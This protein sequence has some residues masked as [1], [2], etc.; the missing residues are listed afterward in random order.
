MNGVRSCYNSSG[1]RITLHGAAREVT[2][3]CYCVETKHTRVLVD[4]GMFQGSSYNDARNFRDFSFDA[5]DIDAVIITHAHLDHIG[6]LPK[7]TKEGFT[8]PIY[9]T[10]P[11]RDIARIVLE[12]ANDIMEEEFKREYRPKLYEREDLERTLTFTKTLNYS[13]WKT[14]G[15]IRF[16]FRDAGHIFGSAFVELEENGG[17]RAVFSGD[18]GNADTPILRPTAQMGTSDAVFIESTYGNRIHEDP[19]TRMDVFKRII[20]RTIRQRGV[21]LIPAFAVERTQAILYD[22]NTFVEERR[23]KPIDAYIDSPM[24]IQVTEVMKRYPEYYDR[25]ALGHVTR[26]DDLFDFPRLQLTRTR[27]ESKMINTSPNPK[28][29]IAGSG[30]MNGGRIKHHLIRYLGKRSTTLFIVGYQANGTLGRSLYEGAKRVTIFHESINVKAKIV[31]IGSF[32]AH[33][34]QH[35][36]IDWIRSA[37]SL[38]K[39]VY[40]THGEEG[41]AVALATKVKD[42]LGIPARAPRFGETITI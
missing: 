23:I 16:R 36:L 42:D 19:G 12:D 29:I 10:P 18:I 26:G 8:G 33:G 17:P 2:G 13:R 9:L 14:I 6:R 40:C 38:T 32:S 20:D 11:T 28:I 25:E 27:N 3:S 30:M 31:S 7:L 5:G 41:A 34:D 22:L 35:K 21:L 24:A 4:C 37:P 39:H 15:D 1:M